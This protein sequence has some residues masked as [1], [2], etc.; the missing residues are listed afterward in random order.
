MWVQSRVGKISWRRTWLPTLVFLLGECHG[1]RSLAGYSPGGHKES[2]MTE[3]T[4]AWHTTLLSPGRNLD[5]G[6]VSVTKL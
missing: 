4:L 6:V 3:A 2:D 5:L 1:Q